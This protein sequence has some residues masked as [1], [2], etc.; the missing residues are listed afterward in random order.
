MTC[1]SGYD[2][3]MLRAYAD[4]EL[5][6]RQQEEIDRHLAE[7][8]T[9]SE[10]L[11][12]IEAD[13]ATVD[14][15]LRG[16][17][18]DPRHVPSAAAAYA[19]LT[20]GQSRPEPAP[21]LVGWLIAWL[22]TAPR[23]L[24]SAA[25]AAITLA[26]ALAFTPLG[27]AAQ[28]FF[29]V[30]RAQ[31]IQ[32]IKLSTDTVRQIPG[33]DD[34][35]TLDSNVEPEVAVVTSADAARQ[36]GFA[37]Q[38]PQRLPADFA[39]K[40]VYTVWEP[41]TLTYTYDAAKIDAYWKGKGLAGQPPAEL[42]GLIVKA[43]LPKTVVQFHGDTETVEAVST[44]IA[45]QGSGAPVPT[46]TKR[47]PR[48][49]VIAQNRGPQIEAPSGID[50]AKLR[51]ELLDRGALPQELA[52]Q[53]AAITDWQTTVPVPLVNGESR[54][55][56]VADAKGVLVVPKTG[57]NTPAAGVIWQ[58]GGIWYWAFGTVTEAELLAAV[59]SLG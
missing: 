18:P 49:L 50:V 13:R 58:K 22:A 52:T 20:S 54:E 36:A 40:A 1:T 10:A 37:V 33:P 39:K 35:G 9:C 19:R 23:A 48:M 21:G 45:S 43:Q 24:P 34:W 46:P 14:A 25:L 55:I 53:L 44:G 6:S 47:T 17:D 8:F 15:S 38:T 57:D 51:Q 27:L 31:N 42:A 5:P 56:T 11:E 7:C 2:E 3:G 12:R 41:M 29:A 28:D 32:T 30:F 59:N 26:A 4:R 16:L